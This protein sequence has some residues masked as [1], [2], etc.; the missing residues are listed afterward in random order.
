LFQ[1][2]PEFKYVATKEEWYKELETSEHAVHLID[3]GGVWCNAYNFKKIPDMV[4][5]KLNQVRH[6]ELHLLI[7][8]K[9]FKHVYTRLRE[10]TDSVIEVRRFPIPKVSRLEEPGKPWFMFYDY[11]DTDM[12]DLAGGYGD[13]EVRKRYHLERRWLLNMG[14]VMSSFDTKHNIS[15][16]EKEVRKDSI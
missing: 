12:Y 10:N 15:Y 16:G 5:E 1:V 2:I 3:E 7:T 6:N 13:P 8:C 9:K 4:Y 14:N 11:Y